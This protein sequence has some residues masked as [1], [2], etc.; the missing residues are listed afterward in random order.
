MLKK[1][2]AGREKSAPRVTSLE[3]DRGDLSTPK[4]EKSELVPTNECC[5]FQNCLFEM[6]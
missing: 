2:D 6:L 1:Q 4:E 3:Q 5:L